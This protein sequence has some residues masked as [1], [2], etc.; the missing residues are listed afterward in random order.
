MLKMDTKMKTETT[1]ATEYGHNWHREL[2]ENDEQPQTETEDQEGPSTS[3]STFC[4]GNGTSSFTPIRIV[5]SSH[6]A[7]TL[8]IYVNIFNQLNNNNI[9]DNEVAPPIR[10]S[11]RSSFRDLDFEAKFDTKVQSGLYDGYVIPPMMIGDIYEYHGLVSLDERFQSTSFW[12]DLLPY[13]KNHVAT[14]NGHIRS[15]P[16][17]SGNQMLLLF[18]KDY[19][20]AL[21]M[22]TPK[23]WSEF[24]RVAATLHNQPLG[25]D[26]EPIYGVCLRRRPTKTAK[27][28]PYGTIQTEITTLESWQ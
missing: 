19:L 11:I 22:P 24:T 21:N 9:D 1:T 3:T 8:Q 23:T 14:Y 7:P 4:Y 10:L 13:Y 5:T 26:G 16:L 20:D 17:F 15:V 25:V 18:R 2:Q 12:D 27:I 28:Q 6:V